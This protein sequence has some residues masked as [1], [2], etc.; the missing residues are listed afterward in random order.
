MAMVKRDGD[1]C[2]GKTVAMGGE[3]GSLPWR[4]QDEGASWDSNDGRGSAWGGAEEVIAGEMAKITA[5][6]S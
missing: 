4:L 2:E 1:D 3:T 5:R 6:V